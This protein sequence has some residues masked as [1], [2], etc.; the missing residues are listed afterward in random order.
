M[1]KLTD[2]IAYTA[3]PIEHHHMPAVS[4]VQIVAKAA[5]LQNKTIASIHGIIHDTHANKEQP[6]HCIKEIE[7]VL[8][9]LRINLMFLEKEIV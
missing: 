7:S 9:E 6:Y 3:K 2:L 4:N 1:R 5:Q 8:E